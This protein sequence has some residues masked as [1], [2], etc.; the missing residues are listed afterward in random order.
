[1]RLCSRI[2]EEGRERERERERPPTQLDFT[3][4][5]NNLPK[6]FLNKNQLV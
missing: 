3:R 5:F 4:Q 1:M 2:Q 6:I